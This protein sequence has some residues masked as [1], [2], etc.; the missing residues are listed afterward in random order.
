MRAGVV[1]GRQNNWGTAQFSRN[2]VYNPGFE[3]D[4]TRAVMIVSRADAEQFLYGDGTGSQADIG[5]ERLMI[6][7]RTECGTARED[8]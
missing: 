5:R 4:F 7:G 2:I 3:G 8:Q 1:L 6:S